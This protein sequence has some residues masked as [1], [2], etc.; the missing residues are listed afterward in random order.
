MD[1]E[2]SLNHQ[3]LLSY[4]LSDSDIASCRSKLAQLAAQTSN[5]TEIEDSASEIILQLLC[6]TM[7][8]AVEFGCQM[9]RNRNSEIVEVKDIRFFMEQ[10]VGVKVPGYGSTILRGKPAH[11]AFPDSLHQQHIARMNL[12]RRHD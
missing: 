3:R 11:P 10:I 8:S 5:G 2:N 12:K 7:Q 4:G 1:S 9:A 6:R